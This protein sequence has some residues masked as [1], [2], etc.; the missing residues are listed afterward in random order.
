MARSKKS[1]SD[2]AAADEPREV[3]SWEDLR[4]TWAYCWMRSTATLASLAVPPPI[5]SWRSR[6][7]AIESLQRLEPR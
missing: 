1:L 6:S 5:R 7:W 2:L 4:P 3:R